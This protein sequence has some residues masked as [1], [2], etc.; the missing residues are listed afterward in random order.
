MTLNFAPVA[1]VIFCEGLE[2]IPWNLEEIQE[3]LE[4]YREGE[5]YFF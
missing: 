3:N 1:F 2:E 4:I 5:K